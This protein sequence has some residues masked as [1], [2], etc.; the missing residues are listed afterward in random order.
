MSDK[1][2][3]GTAPEQRGGREC[4]VPIAGR[5][6]RGSLPMGTNLAPIL[7]TGAG[8]AL[9]QAF[10]MRCAVRNLPCLLVDRHTMD[11]ADADAVERMIREHQP[12]AIVNAAGE[13]RNYIDG[14]GVLAQAAARRGLPLLMFSSAAVLGDSGSRTE[15]APLAPADAL[16]RRQAEA[17]RRVLLAHPGALIVRS[18]DCFG[19]DGDIGLLG[20]ALA[21]LRAGEVVALPSDLMLAPT[22]LPD[23]VDAC[24]DLVLNGEQGIWHLANAGGVPAI[25]VVAHAASLLGLSA[26]KLR[27]RDDADSAQLLCTE[28]GALLPPLPHALARF[29]AASQAAKTERCS[30]ARA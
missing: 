24:L 22:Y 1:A 29:A 5:A 3:G 21:A 4:P 30:A 8:G 13:Q 11:A 27:D 2:A 19:A 12:W 26:R 20:R 7:V 17:E 10:A 28:R 15:S 16:G 9:A 14:A 23:L 25:E 6:R 18:G